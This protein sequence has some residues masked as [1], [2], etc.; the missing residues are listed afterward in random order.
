MRLLVPG[1]DGM[2]ARMLGA[3]AP[4]RGHEAIRV[5]K[6]AWDLADPAASEAALDRHRPDAVVNAAAYTDVD[7]CE[8]RRD[9]AFRVNAE[10]PGILASACARRGIPF[11]HLSTDYVF[12]GEGNVPFREEDATGPLSVYGAS[13]LAG[14]AAVRSAGG[15][16]VILRTAW[17]YGPWGRNFV[18]T[19]L[20][21]AREQGRLKV[22]DDQVGAPTYT[23]D[24]AEAVMRLLEAGATGT[25]HFTNAGRC[26]WHGFARAIVAGVGLDVPVEAV[27]SSAFPR[28][29]RRPA[30][31]VLD[32][33]RYRALAG[34]DPRPWEEA[35]ADFLS[36]HRP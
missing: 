36:T 11:L 23:A 19:I 1:G 28:P 25:V 8:S 2:L 18:A 17:V 20:R 29:A 16:A 7:G 33:S 10:G 24:L 9:L 4:G 31:S 34:R 26:S 15:R 14:E 21:L 6:A 32:L 30:F 3:A 22:V 27:P 13:K 12:S 35:L 5:P